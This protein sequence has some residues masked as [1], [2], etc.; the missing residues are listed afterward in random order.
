MPRL[1]NSQSWRGTNRSSGNACLCGA[2]RGGS[3]TARRPTFGR[4][5][6][7][8]SSC[9]RARIWSISTVTTVT[10]A[11]RHVR[12]VGFKLRNQVQ[13][14]HHA[15][16]VV[17]VTGAM[18]SIH[19][20]HAVRNPRTAGSPTADITNAETSKTEDGRRLCPRGHGTECADIIDDAAQ[21]IRSETFVKSRLALVRKHAPAAACDLLEEMLQQD[22]TR[23]ITATQA[24][25]CPA[26]PACC[27]P[28]PS[29]SS[30]SQLS[31]A[32]PGAQASVHRRQLPRPA[33][34]RR[35]L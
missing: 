19:C 11:A 1:S 3:G 17:L 33:T 9:S 15:A 6:R 2:G 24:P 23:R 28:C 25:T 26:R 14:G 30:Q 18:H 7:S 22:P 27:C 12:V 8:S 20:R 4:W 29:P 16:G 21:K 10:T 32:R 31:A 5:A 34:R 13:G 35:L